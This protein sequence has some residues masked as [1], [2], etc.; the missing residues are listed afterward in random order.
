M[1][2]IKQY[3]KTE[4]KQLQHTLLLR[5]SN[6]LPDGPEGMP[7][8]NV[9]I[10]YVEKRIWRH[11]M[12][13]NGRNQRV[14]ASQASYKSTSSNNSSSMKLIV[15][16]EVKKFSAFYEIR[17]FVTVSIRTSQWSPSSGDLVHTSPARSILISSPYVRSVPPPPSRFPTTIMITFFLRFSRRACNMAVQHKPTKCNSV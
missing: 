3:H 15:V 14:C 6:P 17:M 1:Y 10:R 16:A 5:Y 12:S 4:S 11:S 13:V 8:P 9:R 2:S 7:E